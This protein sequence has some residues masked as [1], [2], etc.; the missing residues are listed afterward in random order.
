MY[1]VRKPVMAAWKAG[2]KPCKTDR[3]LAKMLVDVSAITV[4]RWINGQPIPYAYGRLLAEKTG[5][6]FD[7]IIEAREDT[8]TSVPVT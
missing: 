8:P 2:F 1:L 5:L 4:S 3:D 7:N 6:E